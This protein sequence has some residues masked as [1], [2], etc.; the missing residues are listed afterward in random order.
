MKAKKKGEE[1][2]LSTR[3]RER[4]RGAAWIVLKW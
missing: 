1:D 2:G 3:S 4:N